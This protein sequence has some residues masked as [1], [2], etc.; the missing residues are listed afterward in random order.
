VPTQPEPKRLVVSD[1]SAATKAWWS[2]DRRA[3]YTVAS[4]AIKVSVR[5]GTPIDCTLSQ[6]AQ[7]GVVVPGKHPGLVA[8]FTP[9]VL[10]SDQY[11]NESAFFVK[12]GYTTLVCLLRGIGAS[13]GK[14]Q[15]AFA[16]QDGRDAHD[17]VEWLAAQPFSDGR[18]GVFGESYGAGT[19]YGAAVEQPPHLCAIAPMQSPGTLYDDVNYPGGIEATAGG[20]MNFWPPIAELMSQGAISADEE[21]ALYRAH[22]TYDAFWQERTIRG[23]YDRIQVPV[24]ALGGWTDNFFRSGMLTNV[25][26]LLERTWVFYGQWV[27]TIPVDLGTCDTQ[28]AADPLPGGVLLAWFDRWV[29]ALPNTPIPEKPTFLS[30]EGPAAGGKGWRELSSWLPAGP[31]ALRYELGSDATLTS[32]A[33]ATQPMTFHEPGDTTESG[34]SLTFTTPALEADRVLVGPATLDLRVTL[35]GS[36]ANFYVQLLDVDDKNTEAL[37]NDGFLKASHRSSH[38]DPT[39]VSPGQALDYHIEVRPQHYRFRAGHRVRIRL[40]GGATDTLVQPSPVDITVETGARSK[41]S[42]P[43]FAAVD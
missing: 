32:M 21:F 39:A 2:Y 12:R 36:D 4:S 22:P 42:M 30:F 6:P 5:D 8:E 24:L 25:E 18:I 34:V 38:T 27:H 26:P 11:Q 43:G 29:M 13:G 17:L 33:S 37:V 3:S 41:L 15:H 35:S 28:C 20:P 31:D 7:D 19:T 10:Q 16:P 40:W 23:R 9:Y 14:W 1:P